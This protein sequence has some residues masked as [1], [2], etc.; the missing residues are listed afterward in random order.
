MVKST[1]TRGF[2]NQIRRALFQEEDEE[3]ENLTESS[4]IASNPKQSNKARRGQ[5][6]R[7]SQHNNNNNEGVMSVLAGIDNNSLVQTTTR[8]RG[9]VQEERGMSVLAGLDSNLVKSNSNCSM[10]HLASEDSRGVS[11]LADEME[12][13]EGVV[14]TRKSESNANDVGQGGLLSMFGGEVAVSQNQKKI[15]A[16]N[17]GGG[18]LGAVGI[19]GGAATNRRNKNTKRAQHSKRVSWASESSLVQ[20]STFSTAISTSNAHGAMGKESL[21]GGWPTTISNTTRPSR[22]RRHNNGTSHQPRPFSIMQQD[23]TTAR[24]RRAARRTAT[25]MKEDSFSSESDSDM[26]STPEKSMDSDDN[27]DNEILA[28]NSPEPTMDEA[29][30]DSA[31]KPTKRA[32]TRRTPEKLE[33]DD[34]PSSSESADSRT[35]FSS[36][37]QQDVTREP[38]QS[39]SSSPL[40]PASKV[41]EVEYIPPP[42]VYT[43]KAS[44][45][46][47]AADVNVLAM[48][49]RRMSISVEQPPATHDDDNAAPTSPSPT[50]VAA[51]EAKTR[52]MSISAPEKRRSRRRPIPTDRYTPSVAKK[53]D[54]QQQQQE[55]VATDDQDNNADDESMAPT[56]PD[57]PPSPT[58]MDMDDTKEEV[59]VAA[60]EPAVATR[61]SAR[62]QIPTDRFSPSVALKQAQY[63]TDDRNKKVGSKPPRAATKSI[64]KNNGRPPR[65]RLP[66]QA[67][68]VEPPLEDEETMTTTAAAGESQE[69]SVGIDFEQDDETNAEWT[70][71]QLLQLKQSHAEVDPTSTTFW[72]DLAQQVHGRSAQECR[73]K[74]FSLVKTPAPR[75]RKPKAKQD[76][77]ANAMDHAQEV[78]AAVQSHNDIYD[79]DEDDI[80]NST[81]MRGILFPSNN[82]TMLEEDESASVEHNNNDKNDDMEMDFDVGSPVVMSARRNRRVSTEYDDGSSSNEHQPLQ[83]KVGYKSYMMGLKRGVAKALQEDKKKKKKKPTSKRVDGSSKTFTESVGNDAQGVSLKG[84]LSPGGTLQ[85]KN[86]TEADDDF[87]DYL[88]EPSDEDD[89]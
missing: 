71:A 54:R 33:V 1:Q 46:A 80:F 17:N 58:P 9:S 88:S 31:S 47:A 67:S 36:V 50:D 61:R 73:D 4:S 35:L 48:E 87:L 28:L 42:S 45:T 57:S 81:P 40:R 53:R 79:D 56:S 11:V 72:T 85:V 63:K 2:M 25:R 76:A 8:A 62:G 64:L 75:V 78:G 14:V 24:S 16:P 89:Y 82:N 41:L 23:E 19:R 29:P 21:T 86:L 70:E 66:P 52:R 68:Q 55:V 6:Q 77:A 83:Q 7:W 10:P 38:I 44:A 5:R 37:A 27:D 34:F 22:D 60:D 18:L 13:D 15:N 59:A 32:Y 51:L 74:W 49:T 84:H 30:Q 43:R 12:E 26:S 3:Q 65:G 20:A 39:S 69:H